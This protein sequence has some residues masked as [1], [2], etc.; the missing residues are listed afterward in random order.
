MSTLDYLAL[1][2][3]HQETILSLSDDTITAALRKACEAH[4]HILEVREKMS[5][6]A[7]IRT[8]HERQDQLEHEADEAWQLALR[9]VPWGTFVAFKRTEGDR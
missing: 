3:G 5:F 7:W 6:G 9:R 4:Q 1:R 2:E 8:L